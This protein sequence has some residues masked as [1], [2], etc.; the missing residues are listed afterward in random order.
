MELWIV[1][2]WKRVVGKPWSFEGVYDSEDAAIA[3]CKTW[4]YFIAPAALNTELPRGILRG[5]YYPL[6]PWDKRTQRAMRRR[7]AAA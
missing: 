4:L 5:C 2:R 7:G 3:A 6:A 1:G